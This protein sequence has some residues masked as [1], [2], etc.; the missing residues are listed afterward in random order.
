[1]N[2]FLT[3]ILQNWKLLIAVILELSMCVGFELHGRHVVQARWDATISNAQSII[4]K[5]N[6]IQDEIN[7]SIGSEYEREIKKINEHFN[8]L[9]ADSLPLTTSGSMSKVPL[10]PCK[11]NAIPYDYGILTK[12][13]EAEINTKRLVDLQKDINQICARFECRK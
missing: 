8:A 3:P 9:V 13:H 5:N 11:S 10:S 7:N 4:I 12:L 6:G 1:M 2:I